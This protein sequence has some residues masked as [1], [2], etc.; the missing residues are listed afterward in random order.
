M[1]TDGFTVDIKEFDELVN[2]CVKD[3]KRKTTYFLRKE[4]KQ[5]K[6]K[7]EN[8]MR[9][10]TRNGHTLQRKTG[11]LMNAVTMQ[12]PYNYFKEYGITK[13]SVKVYGKK[14]GSANGKGFHAHLIEKGHEPGGWH[15]EI[16]GAR[17]VQGFFVYE[18]AGTAFEGKF[19]ND[20]NEFIEGIM[21]FAD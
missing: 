14:D 2:K 4:G 3:Y 1:A 10:A 9:V 21:S 12:K 17:F 6:E 11:N 5:L 7:V 13:D 15:A 18:N 8:Q 20:C 16:A 19:Q